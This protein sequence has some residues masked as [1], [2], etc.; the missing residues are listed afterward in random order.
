MTDNI[1]TGRFRQIERA[2]AQRQ[3]FNVVMPQR[4]SANDD[5][6]QARPRQKLSTAAVRMAIMYPH[7][8]IERFEPAPTA[9]GWSVRWQHVFGTRKGAAQ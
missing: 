1:L 8:R 4:T 3:R 2:W 6:V 7:L 9:S 5:A